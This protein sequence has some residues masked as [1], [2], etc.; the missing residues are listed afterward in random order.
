M[1]IS[2][3]LHDERELVIKPLKTWFENKNWDVKVP[4]KDSSKGWDL[5]VRRKNLDLLI[6][7]KYIKG[8]FINSFSSLVTSPLTNRSETFMK[9][10]ANS[11]CSKRCWAIGSGYAQRDIYQLLFD[12]FI[13]EPQFWEHYHQDLNIAYVYFVKGGKVSKIS[14]EKLLK[15]SIIY[16]KDTATENIAGKRKIAAQLM[17]NYIPK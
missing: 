9:R 5:Q 7:A 8:P 16:G 3:R 4:D 17:K 14:F 13:R 10:K 2:E 15:L 12:Y 11:W 6:E 1:P